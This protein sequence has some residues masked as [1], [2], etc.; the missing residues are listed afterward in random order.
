MSRSILVMLL[1]ALIALASFSGLRTAYSQGPTVSVQGRVSNGT[2]GS[3]S[4]VAGLTVTLH[5]D[6][7]TRHDH[8]DT[9]VDGDGR[10]SID[11]I[12]HDPTVVYGL[13]VKYQGALYGED[14]DLSAVVPPMVTFTRRPFQVARS[15][16]RSICWAVRPRLR[17]Q[18][19]PPRWRRFVAW[20]PSPTA[21]ASWPI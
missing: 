19:R 18:R 9:T 2:P 10:F 11:E 6:G 12:A 17:P 4:S 15:A 16:D 8:S 21:R 14:V 20:H 13:S 1:T 3:A 5:A 7:G